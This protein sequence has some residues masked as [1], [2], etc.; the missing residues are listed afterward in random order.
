VTET[1]TV[2]H[3]DTG[4]VRTTFF[5]DTGRVIY[6]TAVYR[7]ASVICDAYYT[8]HTNIKKYDPSYKKSGLKVKINS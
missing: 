8:A 2:F 6:N 1:D 3:P 5:K 7:C 4:I